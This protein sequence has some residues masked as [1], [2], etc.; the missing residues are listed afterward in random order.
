MFT[1]FIA[2]I[3]IILTIMT[4]LVT[5]SSVV[6]YQSV[7]IAYERAKYVFNV[8]E[9]IVTAVENTCSKHVDFCKAKEIDGEIVLTIGDISSYLPDSFINSNL[10]GANFN[11]IAIKKNYSTIRLDHNID[12]KESRH[13]Y[14][15]Y[16]SGK[17][18]GTPP[19]CRD[20]IVDNNCSTM[21][22]YHEYPSSTKLMEAL[23]E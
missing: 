7:K 10:N 3:V 16:Y 20:G 8:E 23:S 1:P 6:N 5:S 15:N 13:I 17:K 21:A 22:V 18:Y 9:T 14:I 19:Q 12:N 2:G 4:Y 11:R